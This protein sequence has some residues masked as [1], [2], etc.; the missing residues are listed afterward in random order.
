MTVP[1]LSIVLF[2]PL[3]GALVL[4]GFAPQHR[5]AIRTC[6]LVVMLLTF[7]VS[8]GLF[9]AFDADL[10]QMQFVERVAWIAPLGI[11]YQVGIDGISLPLLLL[12]SM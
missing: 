12:T 1:V 6:A 5:T 4:L 9:L 10:P 2:L 11:S 8:V 7:A 3:A